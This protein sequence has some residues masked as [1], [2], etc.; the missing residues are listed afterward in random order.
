[1]FLQ[2]TGELRMD[3]AQNKAMI[4]LYYLYVTSI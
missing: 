1:M 4:K 2:N 3:T